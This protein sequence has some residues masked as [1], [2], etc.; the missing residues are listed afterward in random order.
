MSHWFGQWL[1]KLYHIDINIVRTPRASV[2]KRYSMEALR[3]VTLVE[4]HL[5]EQVR[6]GLAVDI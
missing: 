2:R 1:E 5:L 4:K 3:Q 6:T